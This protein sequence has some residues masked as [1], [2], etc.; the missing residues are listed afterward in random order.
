MGSSL[1]G[2]SSAHPAGRLHGL[3][4]ATD[5]RQTPAPINLLD[6]ASRPR[7]VS[8]SQ[9]DSQQDVDCQEDCHSHKEGGPHKATGTSML[10]WYVSC[11]Q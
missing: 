8:D 7:G 3:H 11:E 5:A 9:L 6:F 1:T 4:D 10:S 2:G